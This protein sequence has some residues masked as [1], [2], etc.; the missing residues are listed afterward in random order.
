EAIDHVLKRHFGTFYQA[1]RTA[2]EPPKGKYTFVAQ[3]GM[4]GVIL[5]PPNYHDYQNQLRKLHAERFA[6]MPF[7][8]FKAR[9]KIVRDEEVV[10]K[11][12]EDQSYKTEYICLNLPEPLRLGSREE[13]EKHFRETHLSNIVKQVET[14]HLTGVASRNIRA[15]E[16]M[17]LVRLRWED[18]K[19]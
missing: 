7:D 8:D 2:T 1:E 3:C 19:R 5:G 17:R 9:V 15:R 12:L 10:K 16:L 18:E 4:S 6:R 14:H 11:W 13:V